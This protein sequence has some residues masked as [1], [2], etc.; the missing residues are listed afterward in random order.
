MKLI[1]KAS[2]ETVVKMSKSEW[3]QI[4]KT[5][6]W[7]KSAEGE[8]QGIGPSNL[9][10]ISIPRSQD[11]SEIKKLMQLSKGTGWCTQREEMAAQYLAKHDFH[12]LVSGGK[13]KLVL[14]VRDGK[15]QDILDDKNGRDGFGPWELKAI[16]D[17][18]KRNN[19]DL[20]GAQ[21][22]QQSKKWLEDYMK[23]HF[24]LM[25]MNLSR[26]KKKPG[27][28]QAPQEPQKIEENK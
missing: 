2:G 8:E 14:T 24:E 22:Y 23:G 28:E 27:S 25:M 4:G 10:F 3:L 6:G 21:G 15:L 13:T 12:I 18:A 11:P 16:E 5:A 20:S 1:K 9:R 26:G 19:I 7:T 17:L